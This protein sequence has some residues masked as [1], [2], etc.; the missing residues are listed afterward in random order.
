DVWV[1]SASSQ[2][3]VERFAA[4]VNIKADHVI[5]IRNVLDQG[6][7]TYGIESCGGAPTNSLITYI[8][9]KRCW[10]NK[11][12]FGVED[13]MA[14]QKGPDDRRQVCAAGDSSTDITFVQDATAMK[15]VLNRNKAELMC[16]AYRNYGG[17]WLINPMFI[18]PKP[19]LKTAYPCSTTAC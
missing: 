3:V 17:R 11:G 12:I 6:K 9:G 1:V 7:L 8:D 15:L 16:N 4:K 2:N 14:L 10:I 5:G 19:A 13:V 18:Q